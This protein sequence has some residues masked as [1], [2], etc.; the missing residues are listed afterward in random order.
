MGLYIS[1]AWHSEEG[2]ITSTKNTLIEGREIKGAL[3]KIR[4]FLLL[5][6]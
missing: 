4:L 5:A 2:I 3:H 6:A 1:V